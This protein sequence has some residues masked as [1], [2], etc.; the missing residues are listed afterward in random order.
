MKRRVRNIIFGFFA[1]GFMAALLGVFSFFYI[2]VTLPPPELIQD[3]RVAE[4][5]KIYDRTGAV[6]L[7]EIHSEERRTVIAFEEIPDTVKQATI[8]AEDANFYKHPAFDWRAVARALAVNLLEGRIAQGGSTITQQ[9][10]KNAFL[11]PERTITRKIREL[12][13]AFRLEE[14]YT[15]DQILELYLNQIPYG[16]N[17]YGIEAASE[18]FFGKPARKLSLAEAA[19]LAALPKAPSYYSPWGENKEALALRQHYVLDTMR[20][21][22]FISENASEK[23]GKEKLIFQKP[24]RGIKA[25][26]FVMMVVDRLNRQYGEESVRT[27][28]LSVITTLDWNLQQ[29]AERAV[30]EGVER[31]ARLYKGKNA[32]LV[33]QDPKTGQILALVGSADYF[34]SENEGNFNVAAQGLRQ[35]GSAIKPFIYGRAFEK[36]YTPDTVVFDLETEF[37]TTKDPEKSYKPGNYDGRFRGPITLRKALAQSINVPAVKTLYLVGLPDA[38]EAAR[39]FGIT[40][41]TEKSRYGLSLVLGGGEV[42]LV[43]LVGAYSVFADD[44]TRHQQSLV[45]ETRRKDKILESWKDQSGR[46]VEARVARFINDILSDQQA[47]APIFGTSL[48]LQ[49]LAEHQVAAKTGTTNDFRDAWAIGYTP[50]FVAGVWAGNN[51]NSPMT[52]EGA[53]IAAAVPIWRSFMSDSLKQKQS[54]VF[55]KPELETPEKPVLRGEYIARY[56]SGTEIYPQIHEV[57][58]YLKKDDPRGPD[59]QLPETDPQFENWETPV[60]LWAAQNIPDFLLF[61]KPLPPDSKLITQQGQGGNTETLGVQITEPSNGAF[62]A[63]T[64]NLAAMI[65]SPKEIV[66]IETFLNNRLIDARSGKFGNLYEYRFQGNIDNA[67]PQNL[68]NI[69]AYDDKGVKDE[70]GVIIF[71]KPTTP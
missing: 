7:Y 63:R 66:K 1:A 9:L 6:L 49:S 39:R 47:R 64:L 17:A 70:E 13:L 2:I 23:A 27:S 30:S 44:G 33:A 53:S 62:F 32:A 43:D 68:L 5:T 52:K 51:D 25:P 15:K 4:T 18:I 19:L 16:S 22:G 21:L 65:S 59:P 67:E 45:L 10:A 48:V 40:T 41:L 54:A 61:N 60:V 14:R 28:G 55:F 31:N 24:F 8:A 3:R 46:A 57:L 71:S 11:T 35:P 34:D 20:D 38:L 69:V 56:Q 42:K 26:H 12:A 37:D 29:L 50:T 36:G 58:F